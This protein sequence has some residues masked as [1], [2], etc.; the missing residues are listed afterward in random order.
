GSP[1]CW[2]SLVHSIGHRFKIWRQVV[3]ATRPSPLQDNPEILR[4]TLLIRRF[5][6]VTSHIP[7][8]IVTTLSSKERIL[9][10]SYVSCVVIALPRA[11]RAMSDLLQLGSCSVGLP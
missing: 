7:R 5:R 9:V 6:R 4:F 1:L 3:A 10:M 8:R 11:A 2:S